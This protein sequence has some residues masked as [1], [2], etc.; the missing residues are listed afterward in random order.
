MSYLWTSES[1]SSGHP[2]KV[3]D[4]VADAILDLVLGHDPAAKVAVEAVVTRHDQTNHVFLTGEV[5]SKY[6]PSQEELRERVR[7][8]LYEIGYWGNSDIYYDLGF[9]CKHFT[10]HNYLRRQSTEI[11]AAVDSSTQIGAG[12][13]GLM[14]G[15]ARQEAPGVMPLAHYLSRDLL[16]QIEED[17]E[18]LRHDSHGGVWDSFFLPDAKSQVT[19]QYSDAGVAECVDT[20]VVSACHRPDISVEQVREKL[21][22]F[23]ET[24]P[25]RAGSFGPAI[26]SLFNS[27]TKYVLNPSGAWNLGGPASD[28][29]LSGRKIVV[30]QYGPYCPIGGG[31]FSGKDPTKVDRSAAYAGR[32]LAKGIVLSGISN[33]A[34][35]QL[36]YAIGKPEPVS[37]R[38]NLPDS[39]LGEQL[40]KFITENISL[41]PKAIIDRFTLRRPIYRK[42]ACYGHFG[43]WRKGKYVSQNE[44]DRPWEEAEELAGQLLAAVRP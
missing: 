10:L 28:T 29:G 13:Q 24:L 16:F 20:V 4:Q 9:D 3:A 15:Y 6:W 36:S 8:A 41:T 32:W 21:R 23:I 7:L 27:K 2:D 44:S 35:V 33:E 40:A 26:K 5:G 25:N 43:E 14:F 19:I 11:A 22:S 39:S 18:S 31:S 1:V 17:M 34:Q 38:I 42:T 12:D 30:D 37:L